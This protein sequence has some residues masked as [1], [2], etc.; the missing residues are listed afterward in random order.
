MLLQNLMQHRAENPLIES[1]LRILA[2]LQSQ[3]MRH[4]ELERARPITFESARAPSVRRA[5]SHTRSANIQ[6]TNYV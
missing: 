1:L 2:R 5:E 4:K 3:Y 6:I